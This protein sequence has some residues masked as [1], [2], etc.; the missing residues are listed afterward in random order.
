MPNDYFQFKQFIVH[1]RACSMKV[2]TDACILGAWF[3]LKKP[4]ASSILDIGSGTGLLMLMLAQK[5]NT[6][7][8]GVE[9][10]LSSFKQLQENTQQSK[11]SN[12]L[13]VF[14]GDARF[15]LFTTIYDFIICNPPFFENDLVSLKEEDQVAKHSKQLTLE[16]LIIVIEKNLSEN[17]SFGILLPYHRVTYF[18]ELA[19]SKK[20]YPTEIVLVKQTPKHN[21]F[22]AIITYSR[23]SSIIIKET[24]LTIKQEDG[25]YSNSFIDLLKDYY[26]KL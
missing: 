26:L 4:S 11:W 1:Q 10:D 9:I 12:R 23:N 7:I 2:C 5:I 8:H 15:F 16:E 25:I 21:Y 22:R 3:A 19:A 24:E 13:Q 14:E 17:G 18:N 20:F 6:T